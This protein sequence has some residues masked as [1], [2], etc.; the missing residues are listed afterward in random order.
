MGAPCAPTAAGVSPVSRVMRIRSCA[1]TTEGRRRQDKSLTTSKP[2]PTARRS[3]PLESSALLRP[4][5]E[6]SPWRAVSVPVRTLATAPRQPDWGRR[7]SDTGAP[8]RVQRA[9]MKCSDGA[10][11]RLT[12]NGESG[13][14]GGRRPSDGAL[15]DAHAR[16]RTGRRLNDRGFDKTGHAKPRSAW[17][18]FASHAPGSLSPQELS[19]RSA[20]TGPSRRSPVACALRAVARHR[21]LAP[22][23]AR[24]R[25][26]RAGACPILLARFCSPGVVVISRYLIVLRRTSARDW[27]R[28]GREFLGLMVRAGAVVDKI[29]VVSAD[30][31]EG[32]G[33]VIGLFGDVSGAVVRGRGPEAVR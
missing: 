30:F 9:V 13:C 3:M 1:M 29:A 23:R 6:R 12:R 26:P 33:Q 11:A 5:T 20:G 24:E 16:R 15:R 14:S 2:I 28:F 32:L 21:S 7:G 22:S 27:V 18:G 19:S 25:P 8:V 10:Q 17:R 4:S 31:G